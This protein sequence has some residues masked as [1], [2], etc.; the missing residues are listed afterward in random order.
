MDLVLRLNYAICSANCVNGNLAST[1]F[2][3]LLCY[4]LQSIEATIG[5]NA[6]QHNKVN[7]WTSNILE[8][9]LKRLT[10]LGK[11]FKYI[12]KSPLMPSTGVFSRWN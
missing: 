7:Q 1:S 2:P 6:Y 12:G 11:P 10:S 3:I 8:Q 5:V 4:Y 9:C